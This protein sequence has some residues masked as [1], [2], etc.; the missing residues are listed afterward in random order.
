MTR[1]APRADLTGLSG[2]HSPQLAVEVRLNTNESPY[3]PPPAFR[4]AW[5]DA[6]AEV[7]LHRYPDRS[8]R[9]LRRVLSGRL[10]HPVER[11]VCANGSNEVLQ[12][13]LLTYG[14]P[15]RR[16]L[17]F[18]PTY[19][20]H[21]HLARITGTAVTVAPRGADWRIDPQAAVTLVA[22]HRPH[23]VFLCSPNNPTG[24]TEAHEVVT[25]VTDAV[26]THGPGLV[27]IDEAYGEFAPSSALGF[28][29]EDRPL[30]VTRTFSKIWSLAALRLGLG[31]APAWVVTEMERVLLP[32]HLSAATQLAGQVALE[33][34]AEMRTRLELI[35]GERERLTAE[36]SGLPGVQ[37]W[38]SGAN[39]LLF[40][41]PGD[42]RRV[43]ERLV[44]G[45]V[46][47]RD[48]SS[49]PGV[50]GHL[51][52]TVGTRAENDRFCAA[53]GAAL[54]EDDRP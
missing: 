5:L 9:A 14:G 8:A 39:F 31:V 6:L 24:I 7:P 27:V 15:G 48:C 40:R 21:A 52:V 23:L 34:E 29:A 30:V 41:P 43:W 46:L 54:R 11:I 37:V 19:A 13:L 16:A 1:L 20:L 26:A 10:G 2:Y 17:L 49:W 4:Q 45:G 35:V 47:V 22:R 28:V 33:F 12:A 36:L 38:P 51:R 42:A 3:P 25:A 53:L 32:Y 44:A 18:E 50:E